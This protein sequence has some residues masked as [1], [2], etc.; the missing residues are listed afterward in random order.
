MKRQNGEGLANLMLCYRFSSAGLIMRANVEILR[1][2]MR[3]GFS[4]LEEVG[5]DRNVAGC[6]VILSLDW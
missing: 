6:G 5:I 4:A 3:R 1:K 2:E